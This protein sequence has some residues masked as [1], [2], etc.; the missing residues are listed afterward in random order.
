MTNELFGRQDQGYQGGPNEAMNVYGNRTSG[1][2]MWSQEG[3]PYEDPAIVNP[4]ELA[5]F[6]KQV[7]KNDAHHHHSH[8]HH[9]HYEQKDGKR[10]TR[11]D[12]HPDKDGYM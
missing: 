5:S 12:N 11:T 8:H 6:P 10:I 2:N 7:K 1:Y 3:L 9:H 4:Q